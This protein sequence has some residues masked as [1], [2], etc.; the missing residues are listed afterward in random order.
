MGDMPHRCIQKMKG[1]KMRSQFTFFPVGQGMFCSGEVV[2]NRQPFRWVYD[3]GSVKRWQRQLEREVERLRHL[4]GAMYPGPGRPRIELLVISH[5]DLDHVSGIV[6]LLREFDVG[7]LMLPYIPL[8]RRLVLAFRS[9][10]FAHPMAQAFYVNPIEFLRGID[11]ARIGQFLIVLPSSGQAGFGEDEAGEDFPSG[12]DAP[13]DLPSHRVT[14]VTGVLPLGAYPWES[15]SGGAKLSWLMPGGRILTDSKWEFVP[16]NDP[17]P[18]MRATPQFRIAVARI[19]KSLLTGPPEQRTSLL[20]KLKAEYGVQFG[21]KGKNKNEISLFL[22]GAPTVRGRTET[23]VATVPCAPPDPSWR[24]TPCDS[25]QCDV[26]NSGFRRRSKAG[27]LYT[28]DGYLAS[29]KH[30]AR[31]ADFLSPRRMLNIGTLQV[32][33]HGSRNNWRGGLAAELAPHASVFCADRRYMH[34]HPHQ[35]VWDDFKSFGAAIAD[36]TTGTAVIQRH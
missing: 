34:R 9:S 17:K 31:L 35:E 30:L 23:A 2:A 12:G 27:V 32:M 28:G 22:F 36:G 19:A 1:L 20:A 15:T 11:G 13:N 33:H 29:T 8:W 4:Q 26:C 16:Y 24:A 5:F 25:G 14:R 10:R 21:T 3:C 6:R 7:T 18:G